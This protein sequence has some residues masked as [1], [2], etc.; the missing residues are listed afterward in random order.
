M[1]WWPTWSGSG[2]ERS[3]LDRPSPGLPMVPSV[4]HNASML[5]GVRSLAD[6][7]VSE[8]LGRGRLN[9]LYLRVSAR[10]HWFIGSGE[11][12]F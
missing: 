11:L 7:W 8:Y 3:S 4:L 1:L 6:A 10:L 2:A 12:F 5:I 9:F